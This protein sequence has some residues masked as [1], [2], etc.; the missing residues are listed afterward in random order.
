MAYNLDQYSFEDWVDFIFN[1]STEKSDGKEWYWQDQWKFEFADNA[2]QV[3]HLTRLFAHPE[4]LKARYSWEQID[5]GLWFLMASNYTR[6]HTRSYETVDGEV[7][8]NQY[9]Q[10]RKQ[11]KE[12]AEAKGVLPDFGIVRLFNDPRIDFSIREK[13]V[14]AMEN[15]YSR[16]LVGDPVK[17][18]SFMWWDEMGYGYFMKEAFTITADGLKVQEVM[19]Q[20]LGRILGSDSLFFQIC[21]LHGLGHLR[22]PKTEDI[23]R[24]YLANN[25]G[26]PKPVSEY[27]ENCILGTMDRNHIPREY[28]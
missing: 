10:R 14:R 3:E 22:H 5:Q 18:A 21:A 20:T 27:A 23:V 4:I 2:R 17:S 24:E 26:L 11:E 13:C 28:F 25:P 15:L 16:L 1:H 19:F 12:E 6:V 8:L 9:L 7:D